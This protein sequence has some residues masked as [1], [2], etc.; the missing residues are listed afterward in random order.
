MEFRSAPVR[1]LGNPAEIAPQHRPSAPLF[2]K[3]G[4]ICL[5]RT[6]VERPRLH[7]GDCAYPVVHTQHTKCRGDMN[8]HPSFGD[9]QD[10]KSTRL[11]SSHSCAT[12]MP[13]SA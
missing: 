9:A 4:Q 8:L 6:V 13:S 2:E 12:R 10:R 5:V 3:P 7:H 11:N 1:D